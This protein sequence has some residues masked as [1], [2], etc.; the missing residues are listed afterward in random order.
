MH[1]Y[2]YVYIYIYI[3][4]YIRRGLAALV[5]R[6]GRPGRAAAAAD[7]DNDLLFFPKRRMRRGEGGCER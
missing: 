1:T 2:A 6:G 4:M 5:P 7:N 3:Y